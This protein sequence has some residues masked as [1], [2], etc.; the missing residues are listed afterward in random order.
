MAISSSVLRYS[1]WLGSEAFSI[2]ATGVSTAMPASSKPRRMS[3]SRATPMYTTK[4]VP[5]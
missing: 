4:V 1:R 5:P 2:M 3:P